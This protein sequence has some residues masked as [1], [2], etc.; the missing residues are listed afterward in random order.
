VGLIFARRQHG[1]AADRGTDPEVYA[2]FFTNELKQVARE[3][4]DRIYHRR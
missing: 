1:R 3:W 2:Y 4:I